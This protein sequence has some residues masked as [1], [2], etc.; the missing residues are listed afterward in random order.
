MMSTSKMI[1]GLSAFAVLAILGGAP[2]VP[3]AQTPSASSSVSVDFND[4]QRLIPP[5]LFGQ[6]LQTVDRGDQI[7]RTD[8]QFDTD[9]LEMLSEIRISTLRY[10][11]GTAADYFHWWQALG[12]QSGRPKQPSGNPNEFYVPLVGPEEFIKLSTALRAV[13]F[14]T[15]NVATGSAAEAAEFAKYFRLRGFPVTYWEVGNEIYFRGHPR[16]RLRRAAAGC[17]RAQGDRLRIGDQERSA[18]RES[19]C[20]RGDWSGAAR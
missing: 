10:P 5:F 8:G 15:A 16:Y 19:L 20:R 9:L 11:G 7:L 13:P 1:R 17:L 2:A 3:A 14:V 6:N 4:V 18:L 12:P